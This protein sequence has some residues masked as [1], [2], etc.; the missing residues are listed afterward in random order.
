MAKL[1]KIAGGLVVLL[2]VAVVLARIVGFDP[3]VTRPGMWLTGEV[4]RTPVTDW[5]FGAKL[6]QLTA[7]QTRQWFLPPL[8]HSVTTTRFH[9]KGRLYLA[10][11][12]PAGISLPDGRHWN[13]NV[14]A[15]PHV[16]IRIG[17]KL[18]DRTLVY[19]SDPIEREEIL[20]AWGPTM[21]APGFF[22]HLWR[23]EPDAEQA[24]E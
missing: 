17:G 12:Y 5:S 15:D 3:G 1:L 19:L 16:R 8:A 14:V 13:R 22:L 20:R 21:F 11:G 18:Y 4:E 7:V 6:P 23:V 24:A 2:V 9:Y 10:S